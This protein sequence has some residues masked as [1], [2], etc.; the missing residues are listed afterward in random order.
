ME[1]EP[2]DERY[3]A[4]ARRVLLFN[5]WY[6]FSFLLLYLAI[7]SWKEQL[8]SSEGEDDLRSLAVRAILHN[9]GADYTE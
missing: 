2:Q 6:D 4:T 3:M 8:Q 1:A 7:V 5:N 9:M